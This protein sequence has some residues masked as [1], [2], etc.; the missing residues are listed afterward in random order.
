MLEDKVDQVVKLNK[1]IA[2]LQA[3]K[4]ALVVEIHADLNHPDNKSKKYYA[5]AYEITL[6]TGRNYKIDIDKYLD[7][8][9]DIN[10]DP[11][12]IKTKY[13]VNTRKL[14]LF[15]QKHAKTFAEF[16]SWTPSKP[17]I[18]IEVKS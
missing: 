8:E 15:E 14:S 13:E 11:I 16:I 10:I 2:E 18:S 9:I 12:N 6:K 3:K 1:E 17:A 5:G 7:M 4:D